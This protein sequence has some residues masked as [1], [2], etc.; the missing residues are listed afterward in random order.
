MQIVVHRQR[1]RGKDPAPRLLRH[2]LFKLLGHGQRRQRES[3][4]ARGTLIPVA[5]A[6]LVDL[7]QPLQAPAIEGGAL[8]SGVEQRRAT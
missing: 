5:V 3:K 6:R 4:V 8:K 2:H 7:F 1:R